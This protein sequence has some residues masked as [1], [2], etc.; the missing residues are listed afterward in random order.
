M[1]PFAG[2]SEARARRR[3]PILDNSEDTDEERSELNLISVISVVSGEVFQARARRKRPQLAK[4][5]I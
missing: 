2:V 1:T 5:K 4:L 3:I